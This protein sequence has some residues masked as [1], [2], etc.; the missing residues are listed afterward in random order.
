[1]SKSTSSHRDQAVALV[2]RLLTQAADGLSRRKDGSREAAESDVHVRVTPPNVCAGKRWTASLW[3]PHGH[4]AGQALMETFSARV[5]SSALHAVSSPDQVSV[6]TTRVETH[7]G[8]VIAWPPRR[9]AV[10]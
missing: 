1:M 6:I 5:M 2:D 7:E 4:K 3:V 8:I 9:T 10:A